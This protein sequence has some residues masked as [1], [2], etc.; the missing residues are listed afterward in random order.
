[1]RCSISRTLVRYWSSFCRSRPSSFAL[2]ERASSST[3]SR[4][5]FCSACRR[6]RFADALARRAAAEQ[7]FE[8]E[9]RIG[10]GRQGLVVRAPG[11]VVFVGAGVTRIAVPGLAHRVA[12]QFE[13]R[14]AR[15]VP[16]LVG[17]DLVDGDAGADVRAR[18]LLDAHAGQEGAAGARV[19]AGAVRAG[20][21]AQVRPDPR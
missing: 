21:G 3:K 15:E 16:D 12:G 13:R 6:L 14:E 1:M 5:E 7:P 8:H 20:I 19:V 18:G 4:M 2:T 10:F 9:P 17:D 11:E